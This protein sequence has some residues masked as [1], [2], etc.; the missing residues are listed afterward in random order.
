MKSFFF[1]VLLFVTCALAAQ[2]PKLIKTL[3]N[4]G[5]ES[6]TQSDRYWRNNQWNG[7][8]FYQG[9]GTTTKLCITNGTDAGTAVVKDLGDNGGLQYIITAKDFVYFTTSKIATVSPVSYEVKLWKSDGTDA[10]TSLIYAWPTFTSINNGPNICSDQGSA[11]NYCMDGTTNLLYF[12]GYDATNGNEL[13]VSDG[14]TA[15][16]KMLKNII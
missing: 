15:G 8:F 13:W 2:N 10:G 11:F 1:F 9:K 5:T 16:T 4:T 3:T 12:N 14:T 6:S 7:L